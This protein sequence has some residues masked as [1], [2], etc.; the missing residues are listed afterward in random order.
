MWLAD[1]EGFPVLADRLDVLTISACE[2]IDNIF[3][4]RLGG[5]GE[6]QSK[7]NRVII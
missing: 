4:L 6:G 2:I 5:G 1:A 3:F 7:V